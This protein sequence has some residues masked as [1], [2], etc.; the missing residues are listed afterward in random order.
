MKAFLFILLTGLILVGSFLLMKPDARIETT[1]QTQAENP[2]AV[3]P[4][5]PEPVTAEI[6]IHNG[7]RQAGPEVIQAKQGDTLKLT[8]TSNQAAEI[9]LHGYDLHLH[10]KAGETDTLEFVAEHS[11]RFEYELHGTGSH[12]HAVLGVVEVLPE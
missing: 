4:P 12:G 8:M 10:L 11:G 7:H 1:V 2:D 9:H 5:P 6:S 3:A